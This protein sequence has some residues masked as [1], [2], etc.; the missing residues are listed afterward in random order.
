M[1]AMNAI[2]PLNLNFYLISTLLII[3]AL[4]P[5]TSEA[6]SVDSWYIMNKCHLNKCGLAV[7]K[8]SCT[9]NDQ[10]PIQGYRYAIG[11]GVEF[12][13]LGGLAATYMR[14][15]FEKDGTTSYRDFFGRKWSELGKDGIYKTDDG[16]YVM[17]CT[18]TK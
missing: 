5:R 9:I 7:T 10:G 18:T 15:T 1:K 12:H 4:F 13:W 11:D 8:V 16:M 2:C 17:N 6:Y 3:S 14:Y